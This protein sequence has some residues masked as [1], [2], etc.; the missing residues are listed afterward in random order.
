MTLLDELMAKRPVAPFEAELKPNQVEEFQERGF[1]QVPRITSDEELAWLRLVYDA[2]FTEKRGSFTGG[3][4]DLSRPYESKGEDLLP[5][6]LNP[7]IRFPQLKQTSF[8]KNGDKLARQLLSVDRGGQIHGWGHM[9][10]KPPRVGESLPWHQDEAYWDPAF[11]YVALGCWMPLD[12]ATLESGC[13]SMIPG[14]HKNDILPHR[15]I[16]ND[17]TVHGLE[18]TPAAADV[19]RAVLLPTPAG[20]AVMH[21]CRMLHMSGPN[22]SPNVRRAYANEWQ[23]VP[24]RRAVPYVRPWVEEGLKEYARSFGTEALELYSADA[25]QAGK[26]N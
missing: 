2:L 7:E 3:Y 18:T 15:H 26:R 13:M 10:R 17:P 9:I 11:D 20:G 25:D 6:I 5:Q 8:W 1:I 19:A 23:G 16:N 4:F 12:E 21:H 14:S 24:V 22:V